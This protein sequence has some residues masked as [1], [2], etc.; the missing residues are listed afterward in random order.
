MKLDGTEYKLG[1]IAAGNHVPLI[2]RGEI[3]LGRKF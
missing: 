1:P 2:K 3:K